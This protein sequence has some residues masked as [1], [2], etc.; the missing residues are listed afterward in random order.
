MKRFMLRIVLVSAFAQW[1]SEVEILTAKLQRSDAI[2]TTTLSTGDVIDASS[3]TSRRTADDLH[4]VLTAPSPTSSGSSARAAS[5][6]PKIEANAACVD[7]YG[8][9]MN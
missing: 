1:L 3:R 2:A 7:A 9:D 6:S 4:T 8:G 5:L